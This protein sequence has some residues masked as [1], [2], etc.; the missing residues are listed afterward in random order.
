MLITTCGFFFLV[1][2]TTTPTTTSTHPSSPLLSSSPSLL[3]VL[4]PP[5]PI[6]AQL[7]PLRLIISPSHRALPCRHRA[8]IVVAFD[9]VAAAL[10]S[11]LLDVPVNSWRTPEAA[12]GKSCV[13]L[14]SKQGVNHRLFTPPALCR[15]CIV[16]RRVVGGACK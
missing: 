6:A 11:R 3:A 13:P 16:C 14:H 7:S 1:A 9:D 10:V 8:A 2:P 12:G 15:K 5:P 4:W